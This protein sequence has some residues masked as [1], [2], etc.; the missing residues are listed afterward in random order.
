MN[1]KELVYLLG[2]YIE[3]TME[4]HLRKE[5]DAHIAMC[6]SCTNFLKT[7]DMTRIICR[8]IRLNE[9]PGEFRERLRSFV[10][11][12][13]QEF[14][15]ELEKYRRMAAEEQ[16]RN[17]E[18]LIRAF[19]ERRLSPALSLLFETHRERCAACGGFIRQL[20]GAGDHK[21]CPEELEEHL[22]GFLDALPPGEEP[23]RS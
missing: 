16:K 19:R 22:A 6:D 23:Y 10:I 15:R 5:L 8:Q 9:L 1:C 13:A 21:P 4:E 14:G 17:V 20:N 11:E 18:D 12:K 2:D 7:Y 3:G